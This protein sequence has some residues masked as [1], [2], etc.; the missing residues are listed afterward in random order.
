MAK[1]YVIGID[2]G[3]ANTA[4][5]IVDAHGTVIAS[6]SLETAEDGNIDDYIEEL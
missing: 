4:L 1:P 2:M 5:G 3:G 6:D